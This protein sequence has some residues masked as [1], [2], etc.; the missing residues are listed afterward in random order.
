[1]SRIL[2]TG[3]AGFVGCHLSARLADNPGNSLLLLDNYSRGRKDED[4]EALLARPNV[5][6]QQA[7]LTDARSLLSLPRDF[8][9]IYHLAAIVGVRRVQ[10]NPDLVLSVNALSTINIFEFA[11]SVPGLKRILFTSTSE[12]YAGTLKHFGIPVPTD[13]KVPLCV[14]DITSERST[15]ALSKMYGEATAFAYA[16]KYNVPVTL[17][18]YHN[19]YGPRMGFLH[20]VPE[21]FVKIAASASIKV[22]SPGQTRAFCYVDDAVQATIRSCESESTRKQ[23]VNIGNSG[24]EITIRDLVRRIAKTAGK[25]VVIEE[26][27]DTPGSP[28]R[29]CPDISKLKKLTGFEPAVA[30]D[31][32]LRRTYEWY[33]PR[34]QQRHE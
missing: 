5:S 32:G 18:R 34:L 7:D 31:E 9:F 1:M 3:A 15:Y 19:V 21:M 10:E 16:G 6:F 12:I 13:E 4:F 11:R 22:A 25:E 20:V 24:E 28:A 14:D 30:L 17:V 27:P 23:I 2:I 8:D 33:K 26:L 29:R